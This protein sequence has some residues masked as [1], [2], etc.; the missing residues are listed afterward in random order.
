[1]EPRL[2]SRVAWAVAAWAAVPLAAWAEALGGGAVEPRLASRVAWAVDSIGKWRSFH[3]LRGMAS[4][5]KCHRDELC[6]PA[7]GTTEPQ[8]RARS[9]RCQCRHRC[10]R[11]RTGRGGGVEPRLEGRVT[12]AVAAWELGEV[13]VMEASGTCSYQSHRRTR[14]AGTRAR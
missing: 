8:R 1:M 12:G 3:R 10:R 7:G 14:T 11:G 13:T 2:A 5:T 4:K 6:N 9:N